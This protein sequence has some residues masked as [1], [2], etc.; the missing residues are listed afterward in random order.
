MTAAELV[1]GFWSLWGLIHPRAI[2]R[3]RPVLIAVELALLIVGCAFWVNTQTGGDSFS[4]EAWGEW[5]CIVPA[6]CWAGTMML[7]GVLVVSGLMHPVTRGRIVIGCIIQIIQFAGLSISAIG[8]G[9]QFVVAVFPM[10]LFV[11]MH[12]ILAWEAAV[13]DPT[14]SS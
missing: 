1:H 5:A 10:I 8:S 14:G 2:D 6:A 12:I 13:Y 7:G 9:G 11:P 3:F 4:P